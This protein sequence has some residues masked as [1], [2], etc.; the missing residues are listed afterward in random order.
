MTRYF[1]KKINETGSMLDTDPSLYTGFEVDPKTGKAV[2][3]GEDDEMNDLELHTKDG[4]PDD[5]KHPNINVQAEAYKPGFVISLVEKSKF[6]P[7]DIAAEGPE[8]FTHTTTAYGLNKSNPLGAEDK[9]AL[10]DKS[11]KNI[12]ANRSGRTQDIGGGWLH[13]HV[14]LHPERRNLSGKSIKVESALSTLKAFQQIVQE[15][16][17][18]KMVW[19][20]TT[21]GQKGYVTPALFVKVYS[22]MLVAEQAKEARAQSGSEQKPMSESKPNMALANELL[23][24][25]LVNNVK[26][27][28]KV[29]REENPMRK[30]MEIFYASKNS[31]ADKDEVKYVP[32]VIK[33]GKAVLPKDSAPV[34]STPEPTPVVEQKKKRVIYW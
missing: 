12:G 27:T 7:E 31:N 4:V 19:E 6:D 25:G 23:A 5:P 9:K 3:K 16:E 29:L 14:P 26:E 15:D 33:E 32:S 8:S 11:G 34:V 17:T 21:T 22:K 30:A 2:K 10:G 1:V 24:L 18:I 20:D 28:A 13:K